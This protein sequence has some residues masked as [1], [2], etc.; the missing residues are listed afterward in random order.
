MN[1]NNSTELIV[2]DKKSIA[3]V[4]IIRKEIRSNA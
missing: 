2:H 3:A 4:D 1:D